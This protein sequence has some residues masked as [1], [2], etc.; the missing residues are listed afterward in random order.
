M[1]MQE[2][3]N[4]ILEIL[5]SFMKDDVI[6]DLYEQGIMPVECIMRRDVASL[7]HT[8]TAYDAAML[9][10]EKGTE[11]I[12]VTAYG[13]LFG[14]IT[15]RDIICM[16]VGLNMPLRNL[17]LSFLAS[18][19]LICVSP[20][21]TVEDAV[22]IMKKYNIRQLPVVDVDKLVGLVTGRDLAMFSYVPE[23]KFCK[24]YPFNDA[25]IQKNMIEKLIEFE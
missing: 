4:G 21:Q 24:N 22:E 7:D 10:M 6:K 12:V 16:V 19:P 18:R 5:D 15:E 11:C 1:M 20:H 9:M 14:M 13:K 17:I 3:P 25:K 2:S 23:I 8:H